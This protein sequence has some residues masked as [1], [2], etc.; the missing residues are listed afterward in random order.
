MIGSSSALL[1]DPKFAKTLFYIDIVN[2]VLVLFTDLVLLFFLPNFYCNIMSIRY[3]NSC[4]DLNENSKP[5]PNLKNLPWSI[6]N[7]VQNILGIY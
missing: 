6:Y 7:R 1:W 5:K 2:I 4:A 3:V